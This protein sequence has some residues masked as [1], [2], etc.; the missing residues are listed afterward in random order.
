MLRVQI[1]KTPL[2]KNI[3]TLLVAVFV[4]HLTT[5]ALPN[6]ITT[7]DF[8][9]LRSNLYIVS[10]DGSTVLMDG[11]LTQYYADYSNNIDGMD[12]RKMSNMSENWGMVRNNTV[13]VIERRHTIEGNDSI[14]FKMWNMRIIRYRL[15]FIA[16]NLDFPGRVGILED[17]FLKTST[18]IDLNGSTY[19]DFSVTSDPASKA[20]D[21]FCLIFSK[22]SVKGL[23]PVN[24]IFASAVLKNNSVNINWKMENGNGLE[25]YII[26]R[27]SDG[28]SFETSK[29][30]NISNNQG[31]TQ[32]QYQDGQPSEGTNYY[33]IAV[34][35]QEGAVSYSNIMKV[36]VPATNQSFAVFPNPVT[37]NTVNLKFANQPAGIYKVTLKNE[38]GQTMLAKDINWGGG[39]NIQKIQPVQLTPTGVYQLIIESPDGKRKVIPLLFVRSS[40]R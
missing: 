14:F 21:R 17:K 10:P 7:G 23:L 18:P 13:Y 36:E 40:F 12:A 28:N 32:Y 1:L 33:R 30:V 27:S 24:Y 25:K 11:A 5:I 9:Q 26:E 37:G 38:F 34:I 19:V 31:G 35:D 3:F 6:N 20:P 2:M 29:T 39:S 4:G 8:A 16:S 15:E 22:P